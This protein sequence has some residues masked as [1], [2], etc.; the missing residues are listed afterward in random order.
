MKTIDRLL[1]KAK[2][3]Y[4]TDSLINAFIYPS[5]TEP[6][7]WVADGRIEIGSANGK[8]MKAVCVC[9]SIDAAIEALYKLSEKHP[10][11]Q[12]IPIFIE[13]LCE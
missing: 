3:E 8:I 7:K 10:N 4:D 11:S 5:E 13:N 12:N 6:G 2:K 9:S 1:I